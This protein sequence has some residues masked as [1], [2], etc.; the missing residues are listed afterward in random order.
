MKF[1][2][3]IYDGSCGFCNKTIM[4][5]AKN[6]TRD[7]LKF[8]SNLSDFGMGLLSKHKINGLESSTIIF[9]EDEK[10]IFIKSVA[11]RSILLRLPFYKLIGHLMFLFPQK[12]TD[13]IYDF[14]SRNRKKIIKNS[15]CEIPNIEIRRKFI[16]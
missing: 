2:Y 13:F 7:K 12:I 3:I 14:I 10:K 4:F 9:L 16:F 8:V 15:T 5:F 1:S 11:I 6:D